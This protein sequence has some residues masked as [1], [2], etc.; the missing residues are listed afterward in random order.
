[1]EL[2]HPDVHWYLP[3][4]RPKGVQGDRLKD[5]LEGARID[6]LADRRAQPIRPVYSEEVRGIYLGLIQGMRKK[7]TRRPVMAGAQTFVIAD[8]K[9]LV[10]QA[11]SP[12]AANAL[13]KLLE[14]PPADT[15]LILTSSAPGRLL[16][17]IRSRTV[18]IHVRPLPEAEVRRFLVEHAGVDDEV[19]AH[20]AALSMGSIGRALG[21]LPGTDAS[22][23]PPLEALR[24]RALEIVETAVA[25]GRGAGFELALSFPPAG[26]RTL[27]DLLAF[28]DEWLRDLAAVAAGAPD[29]VIHRDH[30]D[31]LRTLASAPGYA[32]G[33]APGAIAVVERARILARANVNPQLLVAG[34]VRDLRPSVHAGFPTHSEEV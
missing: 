20:A 9:M 1:V 34:L 14:E 32:A 21:F 7:A 16:P 8:A 27:G 3:L 5:A 31:R 28:V 15:C 19:A 24:R 13:L 26:A 22:A 23:S 2:E 6:A 29:A 25:G 18:P 12:E 10:P 33:A 11:S 17:T 4:V 30:L